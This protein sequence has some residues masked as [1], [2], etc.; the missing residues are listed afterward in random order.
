MD[1]SVSKASGDLY[2]RTVC[3]SPDGR[4]LATGAEDRNIRIW[5]IAKKTILKT[6]KGHEQDIYSL[7]WSLDGRVIVS[8]SGDRTVRVWDAHT[9]HCIRT[10]TNESDAAL[11][12]QT[13]RDSGVTSVAINPFDGRSVVAVCVFFE[14][15]LFQG[16][17][18]EMIRVWDLRTGQLLERF[19]GHSNS[20]YSVAFAPTGRS[21]VSGSLDKTL[22]IWDLSPSTLHHLGSEGAEKRSVE[23]IVNPHFRHSFGG[24]GDFV[25]S[26]GY[27]GYSWM[28]Q[29]P[30][31]EVDWIVSGSKD[32]T[33]TFWNAAPKDKNNTTLHAQFTLQGHK[34]S[35]MF[36][37]GFVDGA[38][39]S[40]ALAPRTSFFATGSGD[41]KARI[42]RITPG[43][44]QP[45]H[46]MPPAP[47]VS[48]PVS[49]HVSA[50]AT[51]PVTAP[52]TTTSP[53]MP[54][55]PLPAKTG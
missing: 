18:D 55:A 15:Q 8:G 32:R 39:I 16:S 45:E 11:P 46:A 54:P 10:M 33:V 12:P 3:F 31:E 36:S 51:A 47:P 49:V 19:T 48:A 2:I 9:G 53:S 14:T 37:L 50:P 44:R 35:G 1:E 28:A 43:A 4:F 27:P 20:V 52:A 13:G 21:V 42:W 34:N 6:L 7:D 38:V 29:F 26:V 5:D 24:H 22:K 41:H 17:L 25:L 40:V 23:T 30:G